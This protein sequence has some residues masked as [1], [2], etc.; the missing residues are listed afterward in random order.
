MRAWLHTFI[1]ESTGDDGADSREMRTGISES[2]LTGP[3]EKTFVSE[4]QALSTLWD[5]YGTHSGCTL[6]ELSVG[7]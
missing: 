6:F 4:N 2:L 7:F 5:K 3:I 1:K